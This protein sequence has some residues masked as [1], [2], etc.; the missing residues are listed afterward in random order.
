MAYAGI[1][2]LQRRIK[3]SVDLVNWQQSV[4]TVGENS[5]Y[6]RTSSV[7]TKFLR[8]SIAFSSQFIAEVSVERHPIICR[9]YWFD[10]CIW[11]GEDSASNRFER[12]NRR[13]INVCAQSLRRRNI[14]F[15]CRI[16]KNIRIAHLPPLTTHRTK[17]SIHERIGFQFALQLSPRDAIVVYKMEICSSIVDSLTH[18]HRLKKNATTNKIKN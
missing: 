9:E 12:I 8:F 10:H 13:L 6:T 5:L 3:I 17:S 1:E 4:H 15:S 16:N 18:T 2:A 7:S 11:A 14:P